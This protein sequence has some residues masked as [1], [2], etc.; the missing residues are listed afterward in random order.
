M[1][2]ISDNEEPIVDGAPNAANKPEARKVRGTGKSENNGQIDLRAVLE[3]PIKLRSDGD[4]RNVPPFEAVVLQ[5]ARKSLVERSIASMKFIIGQAE[6]YQLIKAPPPPMGG[7]FTIPKG[8]PE[9]VEREICTRPEGDK[10]DSMSRIFGILKR[11]F[12][13]RN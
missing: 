4:P 10:P 5:H 2:K 7:T 13:A 8:L 12:N 9:A 11:H 6:K 3:A 1:S